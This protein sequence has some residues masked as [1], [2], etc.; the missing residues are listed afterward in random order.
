VDERGTEG[1]RTIQGRRK[2]GKY[3]KK[4]KFRKN[5]PRDKIQLGNNEG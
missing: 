3:K 2:E 1:T 4:E 5:Q